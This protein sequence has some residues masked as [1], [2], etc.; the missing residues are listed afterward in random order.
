MFNT[1]KNCGYRGSGYIEYRMPS[2]IL[3]WCKYHNCRVTG[4]TCDNWKA[5]DMTVDGASI[6]VLGLST[7]SYNSLKRSGID[8]LGKLSEMTL[9]DFVKTRN[10]GRK[11]LEEIIT[12]AREY[13]ITFK[14]EGET[15]DQN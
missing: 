12:K 4:P 10:I 2:A 6:D 3:C 13:G 8:T 14:W 15:N 9:D 11:S 5:K 7:R 1:C